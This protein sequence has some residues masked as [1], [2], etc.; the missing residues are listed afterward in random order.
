MLF[1]SGLQ[2][3]QVKNI[4]KLNNNPSVSEMGKPGSGERLRERTG[5]LWGN[6]KV[7]LGHDSEYVKNIQTGSLERSCRRIP[8]YLKPLDWMKWPWDSGERATKRAW[9][10]AEEGEA[11]KKGLRWGES[12]ECTLTPSMSPFAAQENSVQAGQLNPS[13]LLL[14][15]PHPLRNPH[16]P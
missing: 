8:T 14:F 12:E 6:L 7:P 13:I 4:D 5:F 3:Y 11:A 9:E 16:Y 2:G 15:F 1:L 10:G